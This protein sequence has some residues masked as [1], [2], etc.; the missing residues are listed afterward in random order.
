[1]DH[2]VKL[3]LKEKTEYMPIEEYARWA[4]LVEALEVIN[5]AAKKSKIDLNKNKDWICSMRSAQN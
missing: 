5:K 1:M 2:K 4:C 3:E